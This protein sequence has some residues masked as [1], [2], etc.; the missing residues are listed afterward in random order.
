MNLSR[1]KTL[2]IGQNVSFPEDMEKPAGSG[3]IE[4]IGTEIQKNIHG[5]EYIWV[6]VKDNASFATSVW[7]TNRLGG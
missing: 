3:K 1:A 4:S 5:K 7:P 2:V 6:S